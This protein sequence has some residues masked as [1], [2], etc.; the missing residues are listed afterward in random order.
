MGKVLCSFNNFWLG[1]A[2]LNLRNSKIEG[3]EEAKTKQNKTKPKQSTF[4]K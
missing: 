3:R 4:T 2:I 1:F